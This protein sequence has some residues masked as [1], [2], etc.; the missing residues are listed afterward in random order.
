L[1]DLQ[2][3]ALLGDGDTQDPFRSFLTASRIRRGQ[4]AADRTRAAGDREGA[5]A[6]RL[7][8]GGDRRRSLVDLQ[9][10]QRDSLTG[11]YMRELGRTT[12]QNQIDRARRSREPFVLAFVDVDGLKAV[13]DHSGHAAGDALL[14]SVVEALEA[15]M[16]SYDPI[17]RVGGD[18]F[19]CGFTNMGLDASERRI[20]EIRAAVETGSAGGSITVGLASLGADESLEQLTARADADMYSRK[21]PPPP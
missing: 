15:K 17:V 8:A 2:T 16:R 20:D 3:D 6:D 18:E 4:A 5:A 12:L 14:L 11:A 13:N 21:R 10:A 7:H 9:Q 19:L 1:A